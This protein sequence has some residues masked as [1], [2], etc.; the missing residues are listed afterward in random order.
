MSTITTA[1]DGLSNR[2]N[3]RFHHLQALVDV[4]PDGEA[5]AN[6]LARSAAARYVVECEQ[7]LGVC[8]TRLI[9][10][11]EAMAAAR[12]AAAMAREAGDT[13]AAQA[14]EQRLLFESERL[15]LVLDPAER[16]RQALQ[17]ALDDGGFVDVAQAQAALLS[18]EE[19]E[20]LMARVEAYQ[21][22]YAT[23]LEDCRA[24]A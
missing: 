17:Q 12:S 5:L 9:K 19:E 20:A 15:G 4:Q 24:E 21:C 22:D 3:E 1:T 6:R 8:E 10:A 13:E 16:A 14:H 2:D 23:T 18:P 11:E 7:E